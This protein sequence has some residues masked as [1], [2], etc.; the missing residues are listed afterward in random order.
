MKESSRIWKFRKQSADRRAKRLLVVD[1]DPARSLRFRLL[2]ILLL[3]GM[4]ITGFYLGMT[5]NSWEL[6]ILRSELATTKTE[7]SEHQEE[8]DVLRRRVAILERGAWINQEAAEEVRLEL[9]RLRE[10]KSIMTRDLRF[11]RGIM[12]PARSG[13]GVGIQSFELLPTSDPRRFQWKMVVVQNAKQHQLQRG[14]LKARVDGFQGEK[15][16]SF[17]LGQLSEHMENDGQNLGFRYFQSIPGDGSWGTLELPADFEPE[18]MEVSIQLTSP[19][20][21]VVTR[22]FEWFIEESE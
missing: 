14:S 4:A 9:V 7:N 6:T 11:L 19:A 1:H 18:A 3:V 17:E 10:E 22:S 20:R 8:L 12:D 15:R 16:A 5:R 21:K 2:I 13:N